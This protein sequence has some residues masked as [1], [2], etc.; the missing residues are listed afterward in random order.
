MRRPT[1]LVMPGTLSR[2]GR[3]LADG[4]ARGLAELLAPTGCV[5]CD[6]GIAPR[7]LFCE[8]CAVTVETAREPTGAFAFEGAVAIAV[9]RLKF[10]QRPDLGVRLAAAMVA[11]ARLAAADL[12]VPVPIH[13]V[14][15]AERGY[16][17]ASLLARPLA[18]ALGIAFA[19][20]ALVRVRNTPMQTSL[21]RAGRLANL[22]RAFVVRPSANGGEAFRNLRGR[23]VLLVDDVRTTG[24]TLHACSA[25]LHEVGARRVFPLVLA[26]RDGSAV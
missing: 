11:P 10:G 17:Q 7:T 13:P 2:V 25:A 22:E 9:R 6:A 24:S 1:R 4:L 18:R 8:A 20:R 5:A 16:N 21:D 12:V 26:C 15:L 23:T 19:P 3:L 14:R